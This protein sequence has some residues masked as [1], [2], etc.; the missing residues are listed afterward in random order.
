MNEQKFTEE[1]QKEI[2][3]IKKKMAIEL[4]KIEKNWHPRATFDSAAERPYVELQKKY[5][6]RLKEIYDSVK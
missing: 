2:D 1:Q 6:K 5:G 3:D 4:E